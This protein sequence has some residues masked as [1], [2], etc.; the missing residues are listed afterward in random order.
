MW[1]GASCEYCNGK[2]CTVCRKKVLTNGCQGKVGG[3]T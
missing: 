3:V 2:Q 1:N